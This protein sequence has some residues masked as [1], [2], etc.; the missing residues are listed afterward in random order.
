MSKSQCVPVYQWKFDGTFVARWQSIGDAAS[1]MGVGRMPIAMCCKGLT[2]KSCGHI[3]TFDDKFPYPGGFVDRN[4]KPVYQWTEQG[5]LLR[6][7]AST[8][9]IPRPYNDKSIESCCA[10]GKNRM[11]GFVWTRTDVFP[12]AKIEA[13]LARNKNPVR[14]P[15]KNK[16]PDDIREKIGSSVELGRVLAERYGV[17]VRHVKHL[18]R[19]YRS[20]K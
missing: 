4:F 16:L 9:D 18:R 8:R 6:R 20:K 2:Q 7:Y 14:A 3:W 15:R 13:A 1:E 19:L 10:N 11:Y 5:E 12:A 17:S